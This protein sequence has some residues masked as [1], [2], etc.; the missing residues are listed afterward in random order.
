MM[1]KK[2]KENEEKQRKTKMEGGKRLRENRNVGFP[3]VFKI[4]PRNQRLND[5][6]FGLF[7][8]RK[9]RKQFN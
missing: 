3:L 1:M 7:G 8:R 2:K 5:N 9:K 6:H 4:S